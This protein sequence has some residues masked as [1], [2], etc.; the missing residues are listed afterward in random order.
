[1]KL[2][3]I[4]SERNWRWILS[5][6]LRALSTLDLVVGSRSGTSIEKESFG[7]RSLPE[8]PMPQFTTLRAET[9]V[10]S[11]IKVATDAFVEYIP[12]MSKSLSITSPLKR[13]VLPS[14][15]VKSLFAMSMALKWKLPDLKV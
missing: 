10:V 4:R 7:S 6:V 8:T 2:P 12:L 13:T 14:E 15:I 3:E 11:A 1:M 5:S 9:A